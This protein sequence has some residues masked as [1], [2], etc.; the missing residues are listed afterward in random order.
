MTTQ[1]EI[2]VALNDLTQEL[3]ETQDQVNEARVAAPTN[4]IVQ[5]IMDRK[6]SDIDLKREFIRL[7]MLDISSRN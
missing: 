5:L 1:I 2:L 6:Q 4:Q 3:D 7:A